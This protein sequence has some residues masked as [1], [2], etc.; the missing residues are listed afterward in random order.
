M[1]KPHQRIITSFRILLFLFS[2]LLPQ[3]PPNADFSVIPP[4]IIQFRIGAKSQ[5]HLKNSIFKIFS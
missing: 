2:P 4:L 3:L 5:K 1:V